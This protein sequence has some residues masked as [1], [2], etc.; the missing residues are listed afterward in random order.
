MR[1]LVPTLIDD[2]TMDYIHSKTGRG[3]I[4]RREIREVLEDPNRK[5]RKNKSS[6]TADI[7][8]TGRAKNGK[9]L[10]VYVTL[11]SEGYYRSEVNNARM[12]DS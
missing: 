11:R 9:R 3:H 12:I 2:K 6:A 1:R 4:T 10:A 8:V 7:I 5:P